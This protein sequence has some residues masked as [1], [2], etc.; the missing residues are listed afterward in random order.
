[1][2]MPNMDGFA[3]VERI[4]QEPEL[5]TAGDHDADFV[6]PT[7]GCRRAARNW[8][9]RRTCSSRSGSPNCARLFAR[10]LGAQKQSGAIPLITRFSL[11]DAHDPTSFLSVLLVEDN[12]VNQ[13][14]TTRADWKGGGTAS[15]LRLT[16]ERRSWRCKAENSILVLMDLQM[17]EMGGLEATALIR[18][19][20]K[21]HTTH[22]PI[23]ALTAH[24][25]TEIASDA[26]QPAWTAIFRSPSGSKNS[27][28]FFRRTWRCESK[29]SMR[30][31]L[32]SEKNEPEKKQNPEGTQRQRR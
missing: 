19:Q 4:R 2:H 29:R 22:Q 25:M 21:E 7:R 28:N 3:L 27:M 6:R 10:V 24:A 15:W 18:D 23:I 1:M 30:L 14:L 12:P 13:R 17:P 32:W 16:A 8:E 26:W 31:K 5:S 11:G 20:E 9:S